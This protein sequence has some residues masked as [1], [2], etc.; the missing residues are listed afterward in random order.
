MG[1]VHFLYPDGNSHAVERDKLPS[2]DNL[3]L[4]AGIPEAGAE[5]VIVLYGGRRTVML[6]HGEGQILGLPVNPEATRIYR[7][8]AMRRGYAADDLPTIA[9][10]AIVLDGFADDRPQGCR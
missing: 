8:A 7:A 9:G 2:Y 3:C 1:V 5:R 10:P 4:T 6:V